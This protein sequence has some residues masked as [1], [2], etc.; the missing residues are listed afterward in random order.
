MLDTIFS[1]CIVTPEELKEL[2]MAI[3][4]MAYLKRILLG[5]IIPQAIFLGF[6]YQYR[7]EDFLMALSCFLILAVII[8]YNFYWKPLLNLKKDLSFQVCDSMEVKVRRI[9]ASGKDIV[10]QT[11]PRFKLTQYDLERFSIPITEINKGL[12]LALKFSRYSKHL[13]N[14]TIN[15]PQ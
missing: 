11:T 10:I 6:V 14:L 4:D 5:S 7:N 8:G 1:S 3:K 15:K 12:T 9:K 13:F 2:Q